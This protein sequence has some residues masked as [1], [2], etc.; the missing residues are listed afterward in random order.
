MTMPTPG[1]DDW[2]PH[3]KQ[4]AALSCPATELFYGGA[5]GGGKSDF[6]LVDFL[7][8]VNKGYG[9]NYQGILFRRTFPELEDLIS[10]ASDLFLP[11]GAKWNEQKKWYTFPKGERLRFRFCE[12]DRD[13]LHYQGH[14]YQWVGWDELPQY[15]TDY[16]YRYILGSRLRSKHGVPCRCRGTGNPGNVGQ[17]WIK[18]RFMGEHPESRIWVDPETGLTRC[19]IKARL[20]DNP[21]LYEGDPEYQQR[22]KVMSPTL[23]KALRE[24][25]WSGRSGQVFEE[26]HENIHLTKPIVIPDDWGKGC[27]MDWG[28][29]K[30]FSIGFWAVSPW[31][32]NYRFREWYGCAPDEPNKGIRKHYGELAKE[33]WEIAS[34]LGIRVMVADSSIWD[35][36][37]DG[38]SIAEAFEAVGF[39]MIKSHKDRLLG[40]QRVHMM[41]QTILQDGKPALQICDKCYAW[42]RTVPDLVADEKRPEDVD[43]NLE[44]HCYDDT[45]YW[46]MSEYSEKPHLLKPRTIDPRQAKDDYDPLTYGLEKAE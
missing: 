21:S 34:E 20:E 3:P 41:M 14:A 9:K 42:K 12:S 24:G 16:P 28:Y 10:R 2:I 6:L 8:L 23:Y 11:L 33:A 22:M 15:P 4:A 5:A 46:L 17:V 40:V 43:T 25:D 36:L 1:P 39:E 19:F 38:T 44:D 35:D 13:I 32:R 31:G 29:A 45:R 18:N 37:G 30:P 26:Y 27:S 7:S